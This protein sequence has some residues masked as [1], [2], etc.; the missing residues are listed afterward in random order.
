MNINS[1]AKKQKLK[2][3]NTIEICGKANREMYLMF[4]PKARRKN[5]TFLY[6]DFMLLSQQLLS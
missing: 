3:K 5:T 4:P 6:L 1:R 2:K